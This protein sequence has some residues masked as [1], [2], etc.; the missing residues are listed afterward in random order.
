MQVKS[1]CI[2]KDTGNGKHQVSQIYLEGQA[3]IDI[4]YNVDRSADIMGH[5]IEKE[6]GISPRKT[7]ETNMSLRA[8]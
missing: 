7:I 6:Y 2:Q 3:I 5:S 8:L 4:M 1:T